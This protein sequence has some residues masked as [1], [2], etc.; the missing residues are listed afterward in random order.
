MPKLKGGTISLWVWFGLS[1][2]IALL[3]LG[4]KYVVTQHFLPYQPYSVL[5]VLNITLAY[6]TGAAFSFLHDTGAWHRWF[7][8]AISI[9]MSVFF[10]SWMMRNRGAPT[11]LLGAFCLLLGGSLGN[12]Y[13]RLRFGTVIDFIDCHYHQY[14]FAIFNVADSAICVGAFL[15]FFSW[16]LHKL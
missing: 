3:D 13:D 11:V 9:G 2:M 8:V 15:L 4:T 10:V 16:R 12:L 6:N 5:P 14:H 7:F 1:G